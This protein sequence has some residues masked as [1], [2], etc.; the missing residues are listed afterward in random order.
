MAR[1]DDEEFKRGAVELMLH[2]GK[3]QSQ[4]ARELDVSG[5]GLNPWKKAYLT[6]QKPTLVSGEMESPEEMVKIIR[7]QHQKSRI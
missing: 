2:S 6:E 4:I 1:R 3:K 7:E 5:Y